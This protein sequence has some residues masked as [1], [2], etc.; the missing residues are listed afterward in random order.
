MV[1]KRPGRD[2]QSEMFALCNSSSKRPNGF[3]V[4][5]E[6]HPNELYSNPSAPQQGSEAQA[7]DPATELL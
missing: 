7:D 3:Q 1:E 5:F 2:G 6:G 4:L